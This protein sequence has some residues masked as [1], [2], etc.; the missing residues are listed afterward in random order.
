MISLTDLITLVAAVGTLTLAAATSWSIYHNI[1]K[2]KEEKRTKRL[3]EKIEKLYS[4]LITEFFKANV[5][6]ANMNEIYRIATINYT[7]A[8][9]ETRMEINK[10]FSTFNKMNDSNRYSMGEV[11]KANYLSLKSTTMK[12][13]AELL[14]E[15]YGDE[16]VS[17]LGQKGIPTLGP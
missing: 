12:E 16:A 15:I 7:L 11:I 3:Y 8:G 1:S 10:S 13:Y 6:N 4:P 17:A 14:K 9:P 5:G 2:E